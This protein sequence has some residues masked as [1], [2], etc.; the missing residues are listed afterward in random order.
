M[1][2]HVHVEQA[3]PKTWQQFEELCADVFAAAWSDPGLVR[4]GRGGQAQDGVDIYGQSGTRWPI[5]LQCKRKSRW[6]VTKLTTTE[7]DDEV[8]EA[9]KFRP[10]LRSFYILTTAP[11]DADLQ[12][13]A[14]MITERYTR[15]GLFDVQ[16]L[17][18]GEI[19]RRA[20]LY[21]A[22]ADKHFGTGGSGPR[23]PLLDTWYASD[24]RL[25]LKGAKLAVTCRELAHEFREWPA[26]RLTL[27]QRESDDLAAAIAAYQGR[28][29]SVRQRKVRLALR[30][31]LARKQ[32]QEAWI[33]RGLTLLLGDP[34]IATWMFTIYR[35]TSDAA[36][37]VTGFVNHELDPDKLLVK[38]GTIRLRLRAP[39]DPETCLSHYISRSQVSSI[40]ELIRQR[41][42]KYGP[43]GHTETVAELPEKVRGSEAIP[44]VIHAILR[45][46]DDG[47]GLEVLRKAGILEIGSWRFELG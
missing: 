47:Q 4:H 21:P 24:G 5:G 34:T 9:R 37:A 13:H 15:R 2:I 23:E 11:D 20:T 33:S 27:R 18:W 39:R 42:E 6:P 38:E 16:V 14:R 28:T 31:K 12:A 44:A 25:E 43:G 3:P 17:G 46:L 40:L 36:R 32:E 29:L 7:I 8:A 1:S 45:Q 19:C 41:N 35:D 30:D 10:Q 26:G 22:V